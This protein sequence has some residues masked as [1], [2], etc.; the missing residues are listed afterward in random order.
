MNG[1]ELT[2]EELG[3]RLRLFRGLNGWSQQKLAD[4]VGTTP[5]NISKY[6]KGGLHDI[7]VI[8]MLSRTLGH[9]L[10]NEK[11]D[12]DGPISM[13][14]QELL[15]ILIK[16]GGS[17]PADTMLF[18]LTDQLF[19][20]RSDDILHELS[21]LVEY[22]LCVREQYAFE[23]FVSPEDTVFITAKG[24]ITYKNMFREKE[25]S[26][27][28][29]IT[30]E[31]KCGGWDSI[32]DEMNESTTL[33]YQ[34][35]RIPH[36]NGYRKDLLGVLHFYSDHP[37]FCD[38]NDEK[39]YEGHDDFLRSFNYYPF[40]VNF[41]NSLTEFLFVDIEGEM[42]EIDYVYNLVDER[43][44]AERNRVWSER[45]RMDPLEVQVLNNF[46]R[47]ED[48][49]VID[50]ERMIADWK[51]EERYKKYGSSMYFNPGYVDPDLEELEKRYGELADKLEAGE[52]VEIDEPD[53][54]IYPHVFLEE[55]T[56]AIKATGTVCPFNWFSKEQLERIL[57]LY[58]RQ[59]STEGEKRAEKEIQ[60]I[61]RE[62]PKVARYYFRFSAEWESNGL[63][64]LC[65][66]LFGVE[67]LMKSLQEEDDRLQEEEEKER[68]ERQKSYK[69]YEVDRQKW[70]ELIA[71]GDLAGAYELYDKHFMCGE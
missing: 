2:A 67:E 25:A 53:S 16:Q 68:E 41:W 45:S 71:Q 15:D 52:K 44:T 63:A 12:K 17:I 6:E 38:E 47:E 32:Q 7:E 3:K 49:N 58:I 60:R 24:V 54:N 64:D 39:Y 23:N 22:G 26:L 11:R 35:R 30:Y 66:K 43:Q 14:G 21:V 5:Q 8:Q 28:N 29:V 19:G 70:E 1:K 51:P 42:R 61:L 50:C 62:N 36:V 56:D 48:C 31:K 18:N 69:E 65:R 20:L 9:D 4:L 55:Y 57:Y 46:L 37:D 27:V 33:E 59:A 34:L 13:I 40:Y 10:M